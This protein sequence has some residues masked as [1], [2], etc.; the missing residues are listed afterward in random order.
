V[1][2]RNGFPTYLRAMLKLAM[3]VKRIS[4]ALPLIE[5]YRLG[6]GGRSD[7]LEDILTHPEP[8]DPFWDG[9]DQRV[10][11]T[12]LPPTLLVGGWWDL[13][14]HQTLDVHARRVAVGLPT[15]LLIGP[16]THTSMVDAGW[17]DV[18]AVALPFLR[19]ELG[20]RPSSVHPASV[21]PARPGGDDLPVR[22]HVGG[23]GGGWRDL[24]TWPPS[25]VS[26]RSW[27]LTPDGALI[28]SSQA[29]RPD[30]SGTAPH[31]VTGQLS[32]I[33][34]DPADPTPSRGGATLAR[35]GGAV[36]LSMD[37]QSE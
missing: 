1:Q 2:S 33:R 26:D 21:Q 14:Q 32:V 37:A 31:A 28:P 17:P 6:F 22:V 13:L 35:P 24:P 27:T 36:C 34:Y 16:W 9:T 30:T 11:A 8:D 10:H 4:R 7:V 19:A 23:E 29:S 12:G 5:S 15:K 3:K 20:V 18:L 25:G